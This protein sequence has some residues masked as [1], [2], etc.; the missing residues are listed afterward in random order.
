MSKGKVARIVTDVIS[1][2]LD[3]NN[4]ELVDVEFVKEGPHRYLRVYIDKDGG[5]SLDDCQ[6][7]S[8]YLNQ[9]LDR[10]DPIEE[11][12]FL[13]VSSPGIDRPLKNENDFIKFKGSKIQVKLYQTLNGQKI[14]NGILLD[15]IDQQLI[16]ENEISGEKIVINKDK[17]AS[18]RLVAE[19]E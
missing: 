4:Y 11:N 5:V 16:I 12:Y 3:E 6:I 15:Y 13:E 2:F 8:T 10:L 7:V 14:I 17:T 9:E 18:V 19:F 1:P